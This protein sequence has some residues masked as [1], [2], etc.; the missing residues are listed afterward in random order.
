LT[1]I[2]K[3]SNIILALTAIAQ[4]AEI[5]YQM[6]DIENETEMA[7]AY[8]VPS[9][10]APTRAYYGYNVRRY[11]HYYN[12]KK[13]YNKPSTYGTTFDK[14]SSYGTNLAAVDGDDET[15]LRRSGTKYN[16]KTTTQSTT[17]KKTYNKP[18]SYGTS[19]GRITYHYSPVYH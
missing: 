16:A 10:F 3:L 15:E 11:A 8:V 7:H 13:T 18:A 17:V 2:M 19:F 14:P 9:R 12:Y 4:G 1:S 6:P 5:S